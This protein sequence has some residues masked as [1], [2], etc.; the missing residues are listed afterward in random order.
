MAATYHDAGYYDEDWRM[1]H[2]GQ[3]SS[4][5]TSPCGAMKEE[6]LKLHFT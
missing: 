1:L 5:N 4:S 3:E 2:S 6:D